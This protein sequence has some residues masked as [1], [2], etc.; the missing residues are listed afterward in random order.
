MGV[1][2]QGLSG[3][4]SSQKSLEV[5]ANNVAN[6]NTVGFKSSKAQFGDVY[7][8]TL[9]QTSAGLAT[10]DGVN[11]VKIRQEFRQGNV[12]STQNPLDLAISGDGFFKV[13]D[14]DGT[15]FLTRNGQFGLDADN[16]IVS[17]T[18]FKVLGYPVA[19]DTGNVLDVAV[20]IQIETD[21]IAP[22]ATDSTTFRFNLDSRVDIPPAA[23][24][25]TFDANDPETY[26]YSSAIVVNNQ[27]GEPKPMQVFW[28]RPDA[29]TAPGPNQWQV[30]ATVDGTEVPIRVRGNPG[31]AF[32]AA[33]AGG[34]A[35]DFN[36]DG[37]LV[38][39]DLSRF[40]VDVTGLTPEF[41]G[42]DANGER[43]IA[44][45]MRNSTQFGTDFHWQNLDQDGYDAAE[46]VNV[47]FSETG[48]MSQNY[49]N[50]ESIQV[51]K[52][53]L[54]KFRNPEGLQPVGN[55]NWRA[56]LQAGPEF[57]NNAGDK[58]FGQVSAG[59]VE[60]AN[61]DLTSEL[62]EMIA[63]QRVYQANSKSIQA[64]DTLLQTVTNLS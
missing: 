21:P 51:A 41:K 9:A 17:N 25:Q 49:A 31:D 36:N 46:F 3:L 40:E 7:A 6:S 1:F 42:A 50:G 19:N 45:D 30:H 13:Q 33:G 4:T 5:T 14:S 24:F 64:Q 43:I 39:P 15:E 61:V 48:I 29:A 62:V 55:N 34:V 32:T 59:A 60:E 18:G 44:I 58:G 20:P 16:N 35:L 2:Q 26:V 52:V 22:K 23:N 12:I 27:L 47:T 54:S 63:T 57:S 37:T 38:D 28:A 53:T 56:T 8:N 10:G 11:V